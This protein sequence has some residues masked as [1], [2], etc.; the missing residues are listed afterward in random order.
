MLVPRQ[1]LLSEQGTWDPSVSPKDSEDEENQQQGKKHNLH[2]SYTLLDFVEIFNFYVMFTSILHM[3]TWCPGRSEK[4][5]GPLE[6][7]L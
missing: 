2:Y 4:A 1:A 3:H 5:L 6:L 7:E